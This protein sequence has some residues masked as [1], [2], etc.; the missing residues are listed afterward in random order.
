MLKQ[1]GTIYFQDGTVKNG[2]I[3]IFFET[4][5]SAKE[6]ITF[7]QNG[8]PGKILVTDVK[9]YKIKDKYYVPRFIDVDGNGIVHLLFVQQLTREGSRIHLYELY[10]RNHGSNANGEDVYS[11]YIST[12]TQPK[13]EVWSISGKYLVPRFD[14]KMSKLVVDCPVL[15]RK[16]QQHNKGY[17]YPQL[18][19]SNQKKAEIV[20]RIIDEYNACK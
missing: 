4:G 5:Y 8:K 7:S 20:K 19:P 1:T 15:A 3:S 18:T 11:Y 2:E 10:Q 13:F 9:G 17:F 14:D 12:P 16:I 6:L